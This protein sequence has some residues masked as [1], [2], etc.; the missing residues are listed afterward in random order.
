MLE[1]FTYRGYEVEIEASAREPDASGAKV[2]VGMSI[3]RRRDCEVLFRER[4]IR[5]LPAGVAITPE[6]A[7]EYRRDEAR[8]R[9]DGALA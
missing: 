8:R 6:R 1:R 7:I 5:M 2:L 9:I 4:P 3:V